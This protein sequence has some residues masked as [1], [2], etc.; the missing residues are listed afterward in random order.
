MNL[1]AVLFDMDGVITD[2][3]KY[4]NRSWPIAFHECGYTD[5]TREDALLQRS[6][7][8]TDA[9]KLWEARYGSAF[10]FEDVHKR[11]TQIVLELMEREGIEAKP[12]VADLLAYL[13]STGIPAAV[14]TATMLERA[15][16]RLASVGLSD[17]FDTVIS[18]SMV[19]IG[20]P[21]PDIYL[22]ACKALG[23]M[24]QHCIALEDSPNGIRSAHDA[25]CLTIMI[26]D[27]TGPT[28][29]LEKMLYDWAPGLT[30][31]I[32]I[33]EHIIQNQ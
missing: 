2:T 14:V 24:P 7:N 16:P 25:G 4:Y 31:V 27:L 26:P 8:H 30:D 32:P 5:Y 28:P 22:Y 12:G 6:L 3:E 19:P 13:K 20:K 11:N 1:E 9:Q 29:E 33:I 18:A 10:C 23:V 21:H 15:L 17:A